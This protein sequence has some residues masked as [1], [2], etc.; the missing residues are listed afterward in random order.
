MYTLTWPSYRSDGVTY[1]VK[2]THGCRVRVNL[3]NSGDTLFKVASL[4]GGGMG[5]GGPG[6]DVDLFVS[7]GV[8]TICMMSVKSIRSAVSVPAMVAC[9]FAP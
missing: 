1:S 6:T 4:G 3:S 2:K 5:G 9:R 8:S 7:R